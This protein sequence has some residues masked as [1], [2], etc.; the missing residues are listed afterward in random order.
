MPADI[1]QLKNFID[2]QFKD[3]AL[4]R[5]ALTHRSYAAETKLKYDNQR[6]EFLGDSVLEIII[7]EYIYKTYPNATEGVMTKL[8]SALAQQDALATLARNRC[9][10]EF[11]LIG[12]A[13]KRPEAQIAIPPCATSLKP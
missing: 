10:G 13:N 6:L 11:L 4:L 12:H 5:Q 8:R 9:L 2:Y 7:T 3:R 1:E